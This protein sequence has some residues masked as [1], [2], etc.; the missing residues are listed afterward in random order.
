MTEG[1]SIHIVMEQYSFGFGLLFW[2]GLFLSA[3]MFYKAFRESACTSGKFE[4]ISG[5]IILVLTF[6]YDANITNIIFS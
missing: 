3:Y 1:E 2:C 4:F 5:L 6:I